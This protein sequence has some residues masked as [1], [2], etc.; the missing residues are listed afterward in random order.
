MRE[1]KERPVLPTPFCNMNKIVRQSSKQI[2][3][4]LSSHPRKLQIS[5]PKLQQLD[6]CC[7]WDEY[8][9]FDHVVRVTWPDHVM[10][11]CSCPIQIQIQIQIQ[12]LYWLRCTILNSLHAQ[13]ERRK[14]TSDPAFFSSR[15]ASCFCAIKNK[16]IMWKRQKKWAAKRKSVFFVFLQMK[17]H[18]NRGERI[19]CP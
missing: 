17:S 13:Q 7:R 1:K 12:I 9:P 10:W 5:R 2:Q 16:Q 4:I 15:T 14:I 8:S 3:R 6:C 19:H 18:W 11:I